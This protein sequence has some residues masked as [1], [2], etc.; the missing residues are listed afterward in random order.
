MALFDMFTVFFWGGGG[1]DAA[2]I[3]SL[4]EDLSKFCTRIDNQ[5]IRKNL[6]KINDIIDNHFIL[7][8]K[9]AEN[10]IERV[11]FK[12][13]ALLLH[14]LLNPTELLQKTNHSCCF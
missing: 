12:I 5:S 1:S 6:H 3:S 8:R 14:F 4:I 13:S 11:N 9:L 10:T 7:L 2:P